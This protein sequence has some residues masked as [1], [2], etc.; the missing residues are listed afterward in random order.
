M[1]K[2]KETQEL[3]AEL[4]DLELDPQDIEDIIAAAR[5]SQQSRTLPSSDDAS[6][7]VLPA[8]A[9]T[10][11]PPPPA[12]PP[13]PTSRPFA[14]KYASDELLKS[15]ANLIKP[16]LDADDTKTTE[17]LV[18]YQAYDPSDRPC[19]VVCTS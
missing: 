19:F 8:V 3:M 13:G 12:A 6:T 4:S 7:I 16:F 1:A 9:V 10:R 17:L 15:H 14:S 2:D 11:P 18:R 5:L